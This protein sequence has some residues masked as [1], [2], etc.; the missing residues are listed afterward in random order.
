MILYDGV[1][2]MLCLGSIG[3]HLPIYLALV[4]FFCDQYK[5]HECSI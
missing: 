5:L 4:P 1:V 3:A 2:F